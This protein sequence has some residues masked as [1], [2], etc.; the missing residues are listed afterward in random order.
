MRVCM[1]GAAANGNSR[2][3]DAVTSGGGI[4]RGYPRRRPR[5]SRLYMGAVRARGGIVVRLMTWA[6]IGA[7]LVF[8]VLGAFAGY[9]A[10]G[11]IEEGATLLWESGL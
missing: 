7:A 4:L 8:L 9:D 1:R 6:F 2:A 3:C 11:L 5:F 10:L